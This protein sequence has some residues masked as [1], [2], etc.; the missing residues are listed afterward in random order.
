MVSTALVAQ[1]TTFIKQSCPNT[2]H[3]LSTNTWEEVSCF[4]SY[5]LYEYIFTITHSVLLTTM[6]SHPFEAPTD[7]L[8]LESHHTTLHASF[9]N[10]YNETYKDLYIC[11]LTFEY[12]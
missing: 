4:K 3:A 11:A 2:S 5:K 9:Y 10:S 6:A 1:L 7:Y 8:A 12:V